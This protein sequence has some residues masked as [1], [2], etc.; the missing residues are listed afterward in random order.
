[1]RLQGIGYGDSRRGILGYYDLARDA[2]AA[3]VKAASKEERAQWKARLED[4]GTRV[5]NALVEMG[6]FGGAARHLES[7]R[8]KGGDAGERL[9]NG[10]LALLH[11]RLGNV[12]AARRHVQGATAMLDPLLSMAEGRFED[13]VDGWKSLGEA[14]DNELVAQN[15]AVCLLYTGHL[16][17]VLPSSPFFPTFHF[18]LFCKET[19]LPQPLLLLLLNPLPWEENQKAGPILTSLI[20]A[21]HAFPALTFNL[22][23]VYELCSE[24]AGAKKA[25]LAEEVAATLA[26][27]TGTGDGEVGKASWGSERGAERVNA[28]FKL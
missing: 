13:A 26:A 20:A 14:S 23:T 25:A 28:D 17:E 18:P 19:H 12:A 4:L 10:R 8:G 11:L 24:R 1:M 9:L 16:D 27:G 7:F 3:I 2:R 6:D 15:L 22:A 21:G 5:G